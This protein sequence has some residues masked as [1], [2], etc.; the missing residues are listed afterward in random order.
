MMASSRQTGKRSAGFT[1]LELLIVL[2]LVGLGAVF[3]IASVDRLASRIDERRWSDLTQQSLTKLRNRAVM[4]GM[5]VKA[6]VN[7]EGG[8]L[9]QIGA[10]EPEKIM[11]LPM[12]FHFVPPSHVSWV[13]GIP[14]RRMPL[15]F[16]PDGTFDEAIFDLVMPSEGRR[17]YRLARFSGKIERTNV[18]QL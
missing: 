10:V 7:Y 15:Y 12:R 4:S 3:A 14:I 1:L 17:R 11:V 18:S 8:E 6:I 13:E 5:T 16:Y 2:A 9:L